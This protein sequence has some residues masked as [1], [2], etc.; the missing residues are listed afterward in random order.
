M[1]ANVDLHFAFIGAGT[2]LFAA[3]VAFAY[4][5]VLP[6][7]FQFLMTFGGDVDKPMITIEKYLSFCH[8][9]VGFRFVFLKCLCHYYI[10]ECWVLFL[11]NFSEKSVAMRFWLFP[12]FPRWSSSWSDQHGDH[13]CSNG[14]IVWT[15][16]YYSWLRCSKNDLDL[17]QSPTE[18]F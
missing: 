6:M 4:F 11:K 18:N 2:S 15:F 14:A 3:G 7:A 1:I 9:V 8:D 16:Y 13:A 10:R 17:E 5:L 12:S